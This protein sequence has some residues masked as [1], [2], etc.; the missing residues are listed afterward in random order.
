[1]SSLPPP[2]QVIAFI[3]FGAWVS[4]APADRRFSIESVV[5]NSRSCASR[6]SQL[7]HRKKSHEFIHTYENALGRIQIHETDLKDQARR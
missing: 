7:V 2:P 5:G 6:K 4:L 3:F 1:M